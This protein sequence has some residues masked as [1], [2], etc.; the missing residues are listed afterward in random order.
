M[1]GSDPRYNADERVFNDRWKQ[2]GDIAKYKK[3]SDSSVPQQTSRFLQTN[4]YIT[5]SS[6]SLAYEVPAEKL[7]KFGLRRL[8]LEM[9]ANDLFYWST[10]KRERGLSYP[11]D[12]SI[13]FSA[14]FSL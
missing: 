6:L 7:K 13:E 3:I 10:A 2:P 1:E 5:L 9:I 11:Y 14:R 4:N 12:R 8:H